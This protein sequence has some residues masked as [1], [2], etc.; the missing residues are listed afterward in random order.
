MP[1]YV[2]LDIEVI[3]PV[4]YE[5]YKK[6]APATVASYGGR[7]L[8]RGGKTETTEGDWKPNR[9]VILEFESFDKAKDWMESPEYSAI[10][11]LRQQSTH[12]KAVILEGLQVSP[13]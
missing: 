4:Q 13:E 10:K 9:L 12:S 8:A 2:L 5:T 7:Y 3:D 11:H 1:A 6:L